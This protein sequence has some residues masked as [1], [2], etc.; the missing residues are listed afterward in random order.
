MIL[1]HFGQKL[2]VGVFLGPN[3]LGPLDLDQ[4]KSIS[5]GPNRVFLGPGNPWTS[6]LEVQ[7]NIHVKIR[8][9]KQGIPWTRYTFDQ[10]LSIGFRS[11]GIE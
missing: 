4:S 7:C 2:W 5:D 10:S 9:T 1:K 8:W 6:H 3:P 11:I